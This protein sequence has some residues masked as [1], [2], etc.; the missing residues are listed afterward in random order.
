[1]ARIGLIPDPCGVPAS[2]AFHWPLS[3]MPAPSHRSIKRSTRGSVRHHP[4]QPS[5]VDGIKNLRM[6]ASNTQLTRSEMMASWMVR[7]AW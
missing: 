7:S 6:S 3:R 2:T 5:V 4:H 1:M